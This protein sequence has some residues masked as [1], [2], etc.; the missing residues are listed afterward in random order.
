MADD[1]RA[2]LDSER[3]AVLALLGANGWS[4]RIP[5]AAWF[6]RLL[7]NSRAIV[8]V[9]DGE[10]VGFARGVTDGMS[11][12]YLSMVVVAE[13]HRRRGLGRRLVLAVMGDDPAITW[14]LRAERP[15]AR[16]FFAGLGFSASPCAMERPRRPAR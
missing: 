1:I 13:P 8:A 11:N 10:V 16:Q 5:D 7:A 4:H 3:P 15:D 2:P 9:A 14:L 6:E 12:G